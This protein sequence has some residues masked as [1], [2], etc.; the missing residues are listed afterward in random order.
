M[1]SNFENLP[2]PA[3]RDAQDYPRLV[4]PNSAVEIPVVGEFVYCKFSDGSIRVVINGKSTMMESGDERRSGGTTVFRGVTLINETENA[5]TITLVIGFGKFDRKIIQGNISITPEVQRASG[6]YADDT[7]YSIALTLSF[8]AGFEPQSFSRKQLTEL[9]Q[10]D[11]ISTKSRGVARGPNDSLVISTGINFGENVYTYTRRD[12]LTGKTLQNFGLRRTGVGGSDYSITHL[13]HYQGDYY[14]VIN[15]NGQNITV[16]NHSGGY[17]VG[18]TQ[19]R[20]EYI[21]YSD[22]LA[23]VL[24]ATGF[25]KNYVE[26]WEIGN[27]GQRLRTIDV[28]GMTGFTDF[29]SMDVKNGILYIADALREDLALI[30]LADDSLIFFEESGWE[31]K[32]GIVVVGRNIFTAQPV[33]GNAIFYK[34]ALEAYEN[35]ARGFARVGEGGGAGVRI[36]EDNGAQFVT[37]APVSVIY[38]ND[39]AIIS[40]EIIRTAIEFYFKKEVTD[41]YLDHVFKFIAVYQGDQTDVLQKNIVQSGGAT[42]LRLK[43]EDDFTIRIPGYIVLTLDNGLTF[44]D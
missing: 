3:N 12:P 34:M 31:S 17:D 41:D 44:K 21:T 14:V 32:E 6:A 19:E 29:D 10:V 2:L 27:P 28:Y 39:G 37:Q 15:A 4:P 40:G 13:A 1:S 30:D 35:T 18:I 9:Y 7:R 23:Y 8:D 36:F 43:I 24:T 16:R 33:S 26:V 22:G 5:K 38:G 42:F 20:P 11:E 25:N